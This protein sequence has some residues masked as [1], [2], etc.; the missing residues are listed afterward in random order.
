MFGRQ[1][2]EA[3]AAEILAFTKT[4]SPTSRR[5]VMDA[6][7]SGQSAQSVAKSIRNAKVRAAAINAR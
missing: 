7:N 6:L 2:K 5:M 3:A 1:S 4:A